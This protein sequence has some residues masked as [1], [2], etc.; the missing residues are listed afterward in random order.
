MKKLT[1]II[2]LIIIGFSSCSDLNNFNRLD[3]DKLDTKEECIEHLKNEIK[4]KSDFENAEF[5]LFNVNGFPT[6]EQQLF[7]A[8][9]LGAINLSLELNL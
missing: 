8:H 9:R 3:S 4:S 2:S 1:V 5:E 7:L 6:A